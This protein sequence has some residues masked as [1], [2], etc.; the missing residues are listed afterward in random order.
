[1]GIEFIHWL[2]QI[3]SVFILP[4]FLSDFINCLLQKYRG[5]VTI[6]PSLSLHD[7]L[8]LLEDIKLHELEAAM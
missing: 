1:M 4:N 8:G 7:L 2:T 3:K 5:H 6:A